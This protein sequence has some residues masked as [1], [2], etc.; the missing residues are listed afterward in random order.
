MPKNRIAEYLDPEV[1]LV[2]GKEPRDEF[3]PFECYPIID[4]MLPLEP[5]ESRHG[6]DL[7]DAVADLRRWE[8][9]RRIEALEHA[10]LSMRGV[11]YPID[12]L[13]PGQ[14]LVEKTIHAQVIYEDGCHIASFVDANI[15]ASGESELDAIEMLKDAIASTFLAFS[16]KEHLLGHEPTRQLAVLREFVRSA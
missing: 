5:V 1:M 15:N 11:I 3:E 13:I 6:K 7:W 12:S 4:P 9:E 8:L 16:E 2:W 14:V 10:A